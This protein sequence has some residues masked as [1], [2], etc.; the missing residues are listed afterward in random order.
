MKTEFVASVSP[1]I[2]W[3]VTAFHGDYRMADTRDTTPA[4]LKRAAQFGRRAGLR[5]VYAGNLPGSV[6]SLENTC[7]PGC[8]AVLVERWAYRVASNRISVDGRCPACSLPIPGRWA[9]S[10]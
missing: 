6:D 3:H 1:D 5:F 8:H 4:M 7:C 2:P 10:R 9:P